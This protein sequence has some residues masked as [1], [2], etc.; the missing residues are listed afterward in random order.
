M[1]MYSLLIRSLL[2]T[3]R[4]VLSSITVSALPFFVLIDIKLECDYTPFRVLSLP[5]LTDGDLP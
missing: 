3:D 5:D 2:S 1:N 4:F